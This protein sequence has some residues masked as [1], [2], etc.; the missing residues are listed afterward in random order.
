MGSLETAEGSQ[1]QQTVFDG[2]AELREQSNI[3]FAY[4]NLVPMWNDIVT[5]PAEYGFDSLGPCLK[6]PETTVNSCETPDT[7]LYWM[8]MSVLAPLQSP[9]L[10]GV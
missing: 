3:N 10:S 2:L 5:S 6:D 8:A 1:F 4:I 9:N 7:V